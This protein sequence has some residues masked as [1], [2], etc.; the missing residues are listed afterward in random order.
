M[1]KSINL[2]KGLE[3]NLLGAITAPEAPVDVPCKSV[4]IDPA[5]FPGITPKLDVREGDVVSVGSPLFHDKTYPSVVVTSPAAGKVSAVVRGERRKL[6]SVVIDIDQEAPAPVKFTTTGITD[7]ASARA[8]LL[9]SG[10]WAMLRQR[11]YDVVPAPD[12]VIRDV[13]VT[14]WDAAPLAPDFRLVLSDDLRYMEA[15]VA[16]LRRITKGKVYVGRDSR[17]P[18]HDIPGAEMVNVNGSYPASNA[19]VL[20]ANVAPVNKGE[21]ILTLDALIL[22]SIGRLMLAGHLVPSVVVAVTG[23]EITKPLYVRTLPGAPVRTLLDGRLSP[24][25]ASR[26]LRVISG[27]VLSGVSVGID[28]Y[29]RYPYRQ[30]TVIPEGDD[31]AEFMGWASMAPGKMSQSRTFPGHFLRNRLFSPDARINGGRR[32]I[33]M[34]GEYDKVLPMD[35]MAEYLIKAIISR[36]IDRMESLGIYEVAPED[37]AAAEYVDT[38]K[39]ELQRIV[40]EGLDYLRDELR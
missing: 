29:L 11:P 33:I 15:G 20:A 4:A 1:S 19:G 13:F 17:N 36:D 6:L 24:D 25:A 14:A 16:V 34:S 9:S 28:G 37:F 12:A 5:D 10:L 39:L 35:I 2:K 26:H 38:S 32:A 7:D 30:V 3:L 23:P 31:V 18:I 40:R 27:N 22:A 21:T 8:L